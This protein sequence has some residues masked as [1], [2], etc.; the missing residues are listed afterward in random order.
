MAQIHH[1]YYDDDR[2]EFV[3]VQH[4]S[5]DHFIQTTCLWILNG[6]VLGGIGLSLLSSYVGTPAELA[7]REEN[8]VLVH[9]LEQTQQTI[10]TLEGE[11]IEISEFDN[12]MYR[13]ILGM[14]PV[15]VSERI[16]GTGGVDPYSDFDLYSEDASE[17][18]RRT[19][20]QLQTLERRLAVQRVSFDEIRN[21]YNENRD[22]L[23]HLPAIRPVNGII[24][25]NFGMRIHPVLNYRRMHEGLDFRA[26]V[27]TPVYATGDAIVSFSSMRGTYGLLIELDHGNGYKTRFAHLSSLAED[28]KQGVQVERGDLIGYSGRSGVVQGPHLHYEVL[29]NGRPADPMYY[30]FADTTPEEY[31]M[32]QETASSNPYSMD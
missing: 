7:L 12:E 28:I 5:R 24:L 25:S 2:C 21:Y 20:G 14:S 13:S 23:R 1:Y 19:T 22:K 26:D 11:V 30:I 18:L 29:I 10:E 6:V 16:G 8:Q 31:L 3:P 15:P 32:Y 17:I 9:Q 4:N 27:G